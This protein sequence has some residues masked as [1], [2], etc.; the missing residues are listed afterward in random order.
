MPFTLRGEIR[1]TPYGAPSLYLYPTGDTRVFHSCVDGSF[2]GLVTA[3]FDAL[4]S[5]T[6]KRVVHGLTIEVTRTGT[7]RKTLV[8]PLPVAGFDVRLMEVD[9]ALVS[10][11][12]F[13]LEL[14][15]EAPEPARQASNAGKRSW[16][17]EA[18]A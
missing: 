8:F 13:F 6:G 4:R 10:R 7:G 9:D 11:A 2:L 5:G 12:Y 16:P 18:Y 17:R 3:L 15:F 1:I 14:P